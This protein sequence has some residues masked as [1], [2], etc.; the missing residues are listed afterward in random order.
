VLDARGRLHPDADN[1]I[2]FEIQGEGKLIGV[3]NG[4]MEDMAADFKGRIRK[5]FHGMC[6]AIVQSTATAGQIRVTAT[7]PELKPASATVAT[8][9]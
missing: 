9:A 7:S 8:R 4:N 2:T 3:D 5:A 6:L 1:E